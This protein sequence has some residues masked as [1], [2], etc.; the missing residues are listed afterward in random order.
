MDVFLLTTF[1][2]VASLGSITK[3]AQRIGR[4]QS[5]VS[6]QIMKLET[7]LGKT[8]FHREQDFSLTQ[9]GEVFYEYAQKSLQLYS[10]LKMRFQEA[11]LQ[12]SVR[13]G[14]PEDF[15][16]L[17]LQDVLVEFVRQHPDVL[18]NVECD[19]TLNLLERFRRQEFDMV[20]VKLCKP[21][22]FPNGVEVWT[23]ALEWVGDG[24]IVEEC[25]GKGISIPLVLAPKPCVYRAR[26]INALE[27]ESLDWHPVFSSTSYAGTVAAVSANLGITVLPKTMIP[28]PLKK[29]NHPKLPK[30]SDTHI[31][32]LKETST[33]HVVNSFEDFII[34]KLRH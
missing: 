31:S 25:L 9:E 34:Q 17:F 3:A 27:G 21:E 22:D 2:E 5:A 23:E 11:P 15:A 16:T 12:G 4:T 19:L 29:I 20:L 13:F 30:L 10:D 8:L 6:Q 33:N 18:I 28:N 32:L 14:L 7:S 26:A 1:V 24:K